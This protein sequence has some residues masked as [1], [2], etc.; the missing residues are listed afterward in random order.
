MLL[1]TK[2]RNVVNS[3]SHSRESMINYSSLVRSKSKMPTIMIKQWHSFFLLMQRSCRYRFDS[4]Q[5]NH[6]VSRSETKWGFHSNNKR[7]SSCPQLTLSRQS[8]T[9][10]DRQTDK[11]NICSSWFWLVDLNQV[12]RREE[13][14]NREKEGERKCSRERINR[15]ERQTK[16]HILNHC[17]SSSLFQRCRQRSSFPSSFFFH[18]Q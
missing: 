9:Q 12:E 16:C 13:R 18:F 2:S 17:S 5:F 14:K 15:K 11:T 6:H 4:I 7:I 10:T 3:S 8:D 1:M